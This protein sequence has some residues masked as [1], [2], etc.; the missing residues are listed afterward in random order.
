MGEPEEQQDGLGATSRPHYAQ[1]MY[2]CAHQPIVNLNNWSWTMSYL[3]IC[4]RRMNHIVVKDHLHSSTDIQEVVSSTT[5]KQ[6]LILDHLLHVQVFT[7]FQHSQ[8]VCLPPPLPRYLTQ[9]A[10]VWAH[11]L[12]VKA[13]AEEWHF[14]ECL[15]QSFGLATSPSPIL[16]TLHTTFI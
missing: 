3:I 13:S 1:S 2:H 12:H 4:F 10:R 14:G 5:L 6:N 16:H 8:S 15:N 9:A 11:L 7:T